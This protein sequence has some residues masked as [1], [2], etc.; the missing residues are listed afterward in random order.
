MITHWRIKT[1]TTTA[2]AL[3]M[4]VVFA[5]VTLSAVHAAPSALS[6]VAKAVKPDAIYCGS[7]V[8][9]GV[10]YW[11]ENGVIGVSAEMTVQQL[12]CTGCDPY[13]YYIEN[14]IWLDAS[15]GGVDYHIATGF[16]EGYQCP[17][18]CYFFE[19][20]R[21]INGGNYTFHYEWNNSKSG[22]I[23][24]GD[25][26][27][28]VSFTIEQAEGTGAWS[29][30]VASPGLGVLNGTS[31]D[32]DMVPSSVH[33]GMR[34]LGNSTLANLGM[35][36]VSFITY[37][38]YELPGP[39]WEFVTNTGNNLEDEPPFDSWWTDPASGNHGGELGVQCAC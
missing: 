34:A 24:S 29:I 13:S 37:T 2:L 17:S 30:S 38:Q 22:L 7:S 1:I 5:A 32:N 36:G 19:D 14:Q 25:Y 39:Q 26:N 23:P 8:C 6:R 33:V 9:R 10:R 12:T 4:V 21:P 28:V 18:E 35:N 16:Y 20:D 11:N 3:L 15:S 31:T 27:Q